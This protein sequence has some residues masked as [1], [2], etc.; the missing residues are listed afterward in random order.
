MKGNHLDTSTS[1]TNTNVRVRSP[2]LPEPALK[3]TGNGSSGGEEEDEVVA[4]G[5]P[6]VLIDDSEP[7]SDSETNDLLSGSVLINGDDK[8]RMLETPSANPHSQSRRSDLSPDCCA[9]GRSRSPASEGLETTPRPGSGFR[10]GVGVVP[11]LIVDDMGEGPGYCGTA[12]LDMGIEMGNQQGWLKEEEFDGLAESDADLDIEL[13]SEVVD[14][15]RSQPHS[16]KPSMASWM[17]RPV[18]PPATAITPSQ[19]QT[20]SGG[21]VRKSLLRMPSTG[22]FSM[23]ISR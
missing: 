18:A 19:G 11:T 4:W 23:G 1:N 5:P 6:E 15:K 14:V 2:Y 20:R 12:G 10:G 9:C 22:R 7:E 8:G 3:Y 13:E 17:T 21:G 16:Q